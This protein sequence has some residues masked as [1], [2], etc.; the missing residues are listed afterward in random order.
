MMLG[1][2]LLSRLPARF[3]LSGWLGAWGSLFGVWSTVFHHLTGR[4]LYPFLDAYRPYAWVGYI[5]IWAMNIAAFAL[6]MGAVK[7]RE[8]LLARRRRPTKVHTH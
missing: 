5:A 6:F 2:L 1:E 7:G 8:A 3:W 4:F